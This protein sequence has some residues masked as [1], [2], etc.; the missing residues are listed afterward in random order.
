[1][2]NVRLPQINIFIGGYSSDPCLPKYY[3]KFIVKV[4]PYYK[5]LLDV[6]RVY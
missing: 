4:N 6:T 2:A 3:K 5:L 1:M